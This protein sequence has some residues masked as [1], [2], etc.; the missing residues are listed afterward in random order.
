MSTEE[1]KAVVR[2]YME[3]GVNKGNVEIADELFAP[4]FI[5]HFAGSPEPMN[6]EGWAQLTNMFQSGFPGQNTNTDDILA[7]GDKVA[8]RFT[9]RGTHQGAFQGIPP[10]GKLVTMTGMAIWR[11]ANGKIAEHWVETDGLGMLQQ[12]GAIPPAEPGST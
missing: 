2:R 7:E 1:N 4:N 6:R 3:E 9:F 11:L 10:T 5:F 12:L 8:A